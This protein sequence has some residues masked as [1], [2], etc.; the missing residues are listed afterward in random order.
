MP[1]HTNFTPDIEEIGFDFDWSEEKVWALDEPVVEMDILD[2]AWHIDYPFFWEN[3]GKYNLRPREVID[4]P[5]EH[6]EEYSRVMNANLSYPLDVMENK[7]RWL[8]LDGL[9][10][11]TKTVI[12]GRKTV[13]VRVI[14]RGR[15]QEILK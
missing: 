3:G 10:R 14:P 15:I 5:E 7:G 12:E 11:L 9:H 4:H 13:L 6:P 2:L 8:L 1:R